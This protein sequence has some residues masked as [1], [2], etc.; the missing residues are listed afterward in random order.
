[1]KVLIG[2]DGSDSAQA[3]IHGLRRAG[4]PRDVEC[5]IVSAAD[6]WPGLPKSV[7]EPADATA[8]SLKPPIV[9]KAE[10][11]AAD[12]RADAQTLATEGSALV[13][14]AFPGWK[15]T[16]EA[17]LGSPSQAL[18]EPSQGTPDLLVVGSQGRSALGRL[19]LGSVSQNVLTHATCS[20]RISR[21]ANKTASGIDASVGTS[22]SAN[23]AALGIDAPVRIILGVDG[24]T[25]S[26]L[27]VRAVASRA[28]PAGTEVKVIAVLDLQF[29]SKLAD[30]S[31]SAWAWVDKGKGDGQA[32]ATRSVEAVAG[33]LRTAGL[34]ATP[35][36]VEGDPKLVLVEEAQHWAADCIFVGAK[37]HSALEKF[38]LG[39][40][41][42]TVS[43]RALCSVEV[44]R[45]AV[46]QLSRR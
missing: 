21:D 34:T 26:A 25:H 27:A 10:A 8:D 1:M 46:R 17:S 40:V 42:A 11:L 43:A 41:S 23:K 20:V 45:Q 31:S 39:S 44:V 3:A 35:L 7:D 32:W 12:S 19:V 18:I 29:W 28:W 14:T 38:L 37:G 24:S 2:Y 22:P 30:P 13:K 6:V 15:V 33:E 36:V 16:S 9:R 4:L 5:R